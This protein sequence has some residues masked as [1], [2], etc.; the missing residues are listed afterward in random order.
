VTSR[1]DLLTPQ[2]QSLVIG[3]QVAKNLSA[4]NLPALWVLNYPEIVLP[5]KYLATWQVCYCVVFI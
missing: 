5:V 3:V 4:T 2:L 1:A